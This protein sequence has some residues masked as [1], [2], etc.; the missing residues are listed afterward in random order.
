MINESRI[1]LALYKKLHLAGHRIIIPNVSWSFLPWEADLISVMKSNYLNEFEIKLTKSDFQNDF[2]KRKHYNLK[3][4]K[5]Y[6]NSPNYFWYIAPIKAIPI[7]IPDYAGLMQIEFVNRYEYGIIFRE[8]RRPKRLHDRKQTDKNLC[9]LLNTM[10]IRYWNM[11]AR[12]DHIAIQKDLF[13]NNA[14]D[15]IEQESKESCFDENN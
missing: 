12:L 9:G 1:Q 14:A 13:E 11:A 7:C 8:I 5:T 15:R 3:N 2:K 10:T 6:W 4:S